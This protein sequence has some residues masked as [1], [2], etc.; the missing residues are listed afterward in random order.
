MSVT[1]RGC[2]R[3]EFTDA[4]VRVRCTLFTCIDA[5]IF[6]EFV[7]CDRRSFASTARE[8]RSALHNV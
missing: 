7:S 2:D 1:G 4:Q 5:L 8:V 3:L 6:I